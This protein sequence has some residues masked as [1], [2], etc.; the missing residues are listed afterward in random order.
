MAKFLGFATF[1]RDHPAL[2]CTP[3]ISNFNLESTGPLKEPT[4]LSNVSWVL[5]C[6]DLEYDLK[7]KAYEMYFLVCV[8][9]CLH[10]W[11]TGVDMSVHIS[12]CT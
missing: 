9:P 7:R 1:K 5:D 8:R 11:G 2:Y 4:H 12:V 10:V 6:Q 3:S